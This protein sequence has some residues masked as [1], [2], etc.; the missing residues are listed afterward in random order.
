[1]K[2]DARHHRGDCQRV[3]QVSLSVWLS[4]V[5]RNV[6]KKLGVGSLGQIL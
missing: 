5:A 1:M 6:I 3:R 2:G 4:K